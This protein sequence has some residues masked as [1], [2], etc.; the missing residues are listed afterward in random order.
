VIALNWAV[1]VAYG[2]AGGL[3]PSNTVFIPDSDLAEPVP[4]GL[5]SRGASHAAADFDGDG[6]TD[7]A[8]GIF[9]ADVGSADSAGAVYVV[10]GSPSGLDTARRQKWAVHLLY[11]SAGGLSARHSRLWSQDSPGVPGKAEE[12]D[13]FAVHW[14]QPTLATGRTRTWLSA[15][16]ANSSVQ[17]RLT[18]AR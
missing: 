2:S 16:Q 1:R 8:V 15:C 18:T 10:Y 3:R 7:L 17:T 12:G 6:Y 13:D 5:E 9:Q 11:G 14:R 4:E